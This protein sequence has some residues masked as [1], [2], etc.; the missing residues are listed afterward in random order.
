MTVYTGITKMFIWVTLNHLKTE[1]HVTHGI[2][3]LK[4]EI[5]DINDMCRH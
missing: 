1:D 5:R 2:D 3:F 4:V